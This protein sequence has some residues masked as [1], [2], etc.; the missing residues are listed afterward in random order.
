MLSPDEQAL[1][2]SEAPDAFVPVKGGWGVKGATNVVLKTAKAA[3]VR[4]ALLAA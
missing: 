2:L 3:P 1:F 4:S